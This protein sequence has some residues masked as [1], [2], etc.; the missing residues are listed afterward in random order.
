MGGGK[1][2]ICLLHYLDQTPL[3]LF[4][5][6]FKHFIYFIFNHFTDFIYIFDVQKSVHI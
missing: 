4:I 3:V 6:F 1:L 5:L 2:C